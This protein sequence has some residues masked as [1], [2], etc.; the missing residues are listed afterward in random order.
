MQASA[1][2]LA[3]LILSP[4]EIDEKIEEAKRCDS[5]FLDH[6][7]LLAVP[8]NV[9]SLTHITALDLSDNSLSKV[10]GIEA[11][12]RLSILTLSANILVSLPSMLCFVHIVKLDLAH[13]HLSV[14][15]KDFGHLTSLREL[16]LSGNSIGS[17]PDSFSRLCRLEIFNIS[18]NRLFVLPYGFSLS[19]LRMLHANN[20][21]LRSLNLGKLPE[22]KELSIRNNPIDSIYFREVPK[23]V[24]V[25]K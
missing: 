20:N 21:E 16:D 9:F 4:R 12:S 11:L 15:P 22:L 5:L 14:L 24:K 19:K 18:S 13:N 10:E 17:L 25:L 1:L 23:G 3:G 7:D 6:A 2:H 8:S